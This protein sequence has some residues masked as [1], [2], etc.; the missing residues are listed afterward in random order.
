MLSER[1]LDLLALIQTHASVV[2][3]DGLEAV[4]DGGF[5]EGRADSAVYTT[6]HSTKDKCPV[7]DKLTDASDLELDEVAHFPVRLSS[8]DVDAEVA[9]DLASAR[10]LD[11]NVRES[12][13][14]CVGV[15]NVFELRVELDA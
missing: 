7:T 6:A 5:H 8:A 4:S 10:C 15:T 12:S 9:E 14:V 1:L 11:P 3:E 13:S 2:D